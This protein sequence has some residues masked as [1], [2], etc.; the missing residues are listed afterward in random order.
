M[1]GNGQCQAACGETILSCPS[2][3]AV[4]C[5]CGNGLCEGG[6]CAA[7]L[8]AEYCV[9]PR[10][11]A[12]PS[13][14]VPAKMYVDLVGDN[15]GSSGDVTLEYGI[16]GSYYGCTI[17]S[18]LGDGVEA[19]CTASYKG[20]I[21]NSNQ[22]FFFMNMNSNDGLRVDTICAYDSG[23]NDIECAGTFNDYGD[24]VAKLGPDVALKSPQVDEQFDDRI[25]ASMRAVEKGTFRA[26]KAAG[27]FFRKFSNSLL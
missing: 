23:D 10:G 27:L 15:S 14:A 17:T 12:P 2:D 22:E 18:T 26:R 25:G 3:C 5:T 7:D 21:S 20:T 1:C 6:A 16:D 24:R 9:G 8:A 13:N 4:A 11:E 19:T